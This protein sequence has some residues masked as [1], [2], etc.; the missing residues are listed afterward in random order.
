MKRHGP[1]Q[2]V[3]SKEVY[4]DPWFRVDRDKVIRPDG[5]PGTYTV[6]HL[7]PG[8]CVLAL[9]E[10]GQVCLTEEFHYAVG[11]VTL[12]AVSGGIEPGEDPL[13]TAKRELKEE[14]GIT[15]EDWRE[16]GTVDPFTASI[17]SPV[18]LYLATQLTFGTQSQE[19]TETICLTMM[20]LRE[21]VRQVVESEIT[22]GPTAVLLLKTWLAVSQNSAKGSMPGFK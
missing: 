11:R 13:E 22:H 12:E 4:S 15:A 3:K 2:I 10:D 9:D 14:L 17:L 1:W 16:L 5:K 21:A 6:V 19:G 7:K 20:P 8:V 18:K